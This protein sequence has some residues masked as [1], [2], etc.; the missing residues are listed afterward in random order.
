M[1]A[2]AMPSV[3]WWVMRVIVEGGADL[4]APAWA[5]LSRARTIEVLQLIRDGEYVTV[6]NDVCQP[7]EV[8]DGLGA[9][10]SAT[11]RALREHERSGVVHKV[12]LNA[13]L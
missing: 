12:V 8:F 2:Q 10:E 9:Q 11:R 6:N 1:T 3:E 13:D 5:K 7:I 4:M